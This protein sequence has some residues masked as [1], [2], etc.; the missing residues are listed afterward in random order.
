MKK[1]LLA[2]SLLT[3]FGTASAD[4]IVADSIADFSGTQGQNSWR[5]GYQAGSLSDYSAASFLEF[6]YFSG[7]SWKL[8]KDSNSAPWT[9]LWADGG[10]PDGTNSETARIA[11]RR[12]V[13]EI[14]GKVS[15]TGVFA[16]AGGG[17]WDGVRGA[18]FVDGTQA[19]STSIAEGGSTNF[20]FGAS[21]AR[22][23]RVDF[24]L[25]PNGTD[26]AD[27]TRF[28]ARIT[29]AVPEPETYAMLLAGLGLMGGIARRRKQK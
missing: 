26:Y 8:N 5:Y 15:I 29:S 28:S 18:I 17:Y 1:S 3:A 11:V 16:D 6:E 25:D 24:V 13:S 20:S 10:H 23:S 12:W 21:V 19:W 4:T 27:S 22:G 14:D 9:Q 2:L 7:T